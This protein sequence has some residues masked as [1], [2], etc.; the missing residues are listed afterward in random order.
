MFPALANSDYQPFRMTPCL[1]NKAQFYFL[2]PQCQSIVGCSFK[3]ETVLQISA[4]F[5]GSK[6]AFSY[7]PFFFFFFPGCLLFFS[8]CLLFQFVVLLSTEIRELLAEG[9]KLNHFTEKI[10]QD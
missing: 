3:Q 8:G 7:C 10:D 5:S 2:L 6:V 9:I 4:T 1:N